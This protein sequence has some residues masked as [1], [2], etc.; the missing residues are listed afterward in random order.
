MKNPWNECVE[1]LAQ[2]KEH[3]AECDKPKVKE[4]ADRIKNKVSG[5]GEIRLNLPPQPFEGNEIGR[6]SCRERV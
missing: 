4:I 5:N 1:S 6:A 2:S 3:F